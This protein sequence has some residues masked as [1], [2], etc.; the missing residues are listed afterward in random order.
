MN[1]EHLKINIEQ[2][3]I[4]RR[5][6]RKKG[7]IGEEINRSSETNDKQPKIPN[8]GIEDEKRI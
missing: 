5:L 6:C 8:A 7:G 1:I 2:P 4:F 3:T